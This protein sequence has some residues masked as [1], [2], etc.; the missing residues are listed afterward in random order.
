MPSQWD[1]LREVLSPW[2]DGSTENRCDSRLGWVTPARLSQTVKGPQGTPRVPAAFAVQSDMDACSASTAHRNCDETQSLI[3][4][5]PLQTHILPKA[6][7]RGKQTARGLP[8][9]HSSTWRS[10]PAR[11]SQHAG[12]RSSAEPEGRGTW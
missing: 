2:Q 10:G 6:F 11:H 1:R 8:V 5:R 9:S 3:I 12:A 7:P 4:P